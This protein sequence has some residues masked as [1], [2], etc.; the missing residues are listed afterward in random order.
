[1]KSQKLLVVALVVG[2]ALAV[3][4]FRP[5]DAFAGVTVCDT[6]PIVTLSNG[7]VVTM[8]DHVSTTQSDLQ[9]V[10]YTLHVPAGVTV[11]NV[12]YDTVFGSL[13]SL[14]VVADQ[15]SGN[16]WQ[17]TVATT[18]T[19]WVPVMATA[20]IAGPSCQKL[21]QTASGVSGQDVTTWFKHC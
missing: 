18:G 2:A 15:A 17:D 5:G 9:T 10:S 16:Y 19:S 4:M 6:D 13:E 12:Q 1:M 3:L 11:T 20:S 7:A 8:V 14:S 21:S